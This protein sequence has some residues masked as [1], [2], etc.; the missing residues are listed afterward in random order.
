MKIFCPWKKWRVGPGKLSLN[1][2]TYNGHS[3]VSLSRRWKRV[4]NEPV[5]DIH[6]PWWSS[7]SDRS[8]IGCRT[9]TERLVH[10]PRLGRDLCKTS[11]SNSLTGERS[12]IRSIDDHKHSLI[13]LTKDWEELDIPPTTT[14]STAPRQQSFSPFSSLNNWFDGRRRRRRSSLLL[15]RIKI[16]V[17]LIN[18][19]VLLTLVISSEYFR[20]V[21]NNY[22]HREI[23]TTTAYLIHSFR[24]QPE[25]NEVYN[26]NPRWERFFFRS[27]L[28]FNDKWLD[29]EFDFE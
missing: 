1:T 26:K 27:V 25:E 2:F 8:T 7:P 19:V 3:I 12:D 6:R 16:S 22:L 4:K 29:V 10:R 15:F 23:T 18:A 9:W 28:R 11:P 20:S 24:G 13:Q 21:F 17:I 14:S 5:W